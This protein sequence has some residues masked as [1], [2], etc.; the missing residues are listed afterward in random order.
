M[1]LSTAEI[2]AI[3]IEKYRWS[4]YATCARARIKQISNFVSSPLLIGYCYSNM[5][6]LYVNVKAKESF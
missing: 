6:I 3:L 1:N 4:E 2:K 5:N